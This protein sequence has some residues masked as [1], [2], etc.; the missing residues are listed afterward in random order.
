[1]KATYSVLVFYRTL[2]TEEKHPKHYNKVKGTAGIHGQLFEYKFCALVFLR[3]INHGLQFKL[4]SNVA[5][6]GVFDDVEIEYLDDISRISHFFV[7]L[8]SKTRQ[9]ITVKNLLAEKGDFSLRKYYESYIEIEEKFNCCEEGVKINGRI[10]ES[11]FIIYTNADVEKGLQSNE[12]IEVGQENFLM[13]GSSVLQFSEEKHK[14]IYEHLQG[15][16]KHR[17]FL[18]R[19]RIMYRQANEKEM[20][21]HITH[22]LQNNMKLSSCEL[23]LAYIYFRDFIKEWWQNC[24]Y[25]L[26]ETN[27]AENDPLQKT[28]ENVRTTLVAKVLEQRKSELGELCIKYKESAIRVMKELIEPNKALLIFAPG[29]STTLTAAKIHQMLSATTHIILNL[30]QLVRY[31]PEVMF[32][33]NNRFN[34]LVV[35]GQNS[36]E[37]FQVIFDE[38]ARILNECGVKKKFVFISSRKGN[39][40][41]IN[42]LRCTFCSKLREEYD[43]WKVTDIITESQKVLLK[44]KVYFQGSELQLNTIVKESDVCMLNALDS[45]SIS[46]LI[47]NEKPSIGVPIDDTLEYYIERTLE[48]SKQCKRGIPYDSDVLPAL[49]EDSLEEPQVTR[50]YRKENFKHKDSDHAAYRTSLATKS[51]KQPTALSNEANHMPSLST[52]DESLL[53]GQNTDDFGNEPLVFE[54]KASTVWRP[55]TLLEGD[56]R[57]ILVIAEP[58]MGK[59]TLLN[60]VAKQTRERH[61]DTWIVRVNINNY[62]SILHRMKTN[63]CD[64]NCA[65]KLL[66]EAAKVKERDGVQLEGELF[67]YSY[68]F[69]GNMVV[70]MDGVDEVSPHY[71]E[72]VIQIL[73]I[74][75]KTKVIKI[76]VTSRHPMKGQLEKEFQ[77]Q[78]YSLIPFSEEDQKRFLVKFWSKKCLDVKPDCLEN[79]ANRVV[80]LSIK[81]LSVGEKHFMGLPLQ[82]MLLAEMFEEN[83]K[84]CYLSGMVNLPEH[85]NLV[86]LYDLYIKKKWDIYLSEKKISDRTNVNVLNDDA[87]LYDSFIDNH[88]AAAL[89][90]IFSR[91]HLEKLTDKDIPK[92]ARDFL[93]K[94]SE[95]LEKTG[96]ISDVID[97]RPVFQHRTCAEYFVARWLCDHK[98]ASQ[99]FLRDHI[100]ELGFG[101]VRRMVD[102]IL[103]KENRVHL[104]VLNSDVRE[105]E[106]LLRRKDSICEKDH[107]GR[108]ALHIAVSSRSPEIIRLLLEHGADIMVPDTFLGLS[109]VQYASRMIDWEMLSLIMEKRPKVREQVLYV[110]KNELM[111]YNFS[112]LRAAAKYGHT[113]LLTY[114]ISKDN[115]VNVPLPGDN[116]T[117]LHEAAQSDQIETVKTLVR[118]GAKPDAADGIGKTP[119]HVSAESGSYNVVKFMVESQDTVQKTN[120]LGNKGIFERTIQ[121]LNRLNA[122]DKYGN[123]PLHLASAAGNTNIVRYL[124]SAGSDLKSRNVRREYPLTLAARCGN[125]DILEFLLKDDC[126]PKYEEAKVSA[127]TA[128]ISAGHVYTMKLLL[129]LGAPVNKGENEKPIHAA[130]RV[131]HQEIVSLL[132][133]H[134]ASLDSRTVNGNTALH[135]ASEAGHISLVKYLVERERNDVNSL[136]SENETPLHLA[137]R[138][139]RENL[140]K[141]LVENGCNINATTDYHATC[142]HVAC[143]NGLY[144]IV[145]YLLKHGANVNAKTSADKTPLHIAASRGQTKIVKLLLLNHANVSL[146]DKDGTTALLAASREGNQET[147]RFIVEHGGNIQDSDNNRNTIAHFAV[148]KE[149]YSTL[150]FLSELDAD[151]DVR[152]CNGHTPLLQAVRQ[153]NIRIVQYLLE[154]NADVNVQGNDGIRP[155]DFAVLKGKLELIR[156]LLE[157]KARSSKAGVHLVEA[158]RFGYLDLL[159]CFVAMGDE[160]NAKTNKG[161]TPLH[162]ACKSGQIN[163]VQ[164]LSEHGA[165]LDLQD[166]SG[167]TALHFAVSRGHINVT[168]ALVEK[169][170]NLEVVN[171]AGSTAL[172]IAAKNG[173]LNIARFL[174]ENG[175]KVD[176]RNDKNETALLVATAQGHENIVKVLMAHGAGIGVR[177]IVGTT[178]LDIA[179]E[180]GYF[181]IT[182]LIKDR[183]EGRMLICSERPSELNIAAE[184]GHLEEV[185]RLVKAGMP[186]DYGDRFGR[187]ALWGAASKGHNAIIRF[188]TESGSC[189]NIPDSEGVTPI[190]I[191]ARM[192]HWEAVDEFMEHDP[193]IRP[194]SAEYL[195]VHLHRASASDDMTDLRILLKCGI[196]VD[197]KNE[198]G[199]TPLHVAANHGYKE[200]TQLLLN[201]GANVSI[202]DRDGKTPLIS[203]AENGYVELVQDLVNADAILDVTCKDGLTP[204]I[205]AARYGHVEVCREL[206]RGGSNVNLQDNLSCTP[207][208]SAATNGHAKVI[209]VLLYHGA[210]VDIPDKSG[211]TPLSSAAENGHVEVIEDLLDH[212]ANVDTADK[213]GRTPLISAAANGHLEVIRNLLH[214][215]ASV[216]IADKNGRTPLSSGAENGNVEVTRELL[217][218]GASVNIVD[219]HGCTPLRFSARNGH[220]EVIR[221]LINHGASVD[222]RDNLGFTALSNAAWLGHLDVVRLLLENHAN[223]DNVSNT[224]ITAVHLA[225]VKGYFSVVELLVYNN[226]NTSIRSI[227]GRTA[228]DCAYDQR[229]YDI[230]KY[231]RRVTELL[232]EWKEATSQY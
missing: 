47:A 169:S 92:V 207:L 201:N 143:E 67:I 66:T 222:I 164:Y 229:H 122:R 168:Q 87:A 129:R 219:I 14:D 57:V 159:H 30:Q 203:A 151:L 130:S 131:G 189:T 11:L 209:R 127:L 37:N 63:V 154:K 99:T 93:K 198:D 39:I 153:G 3:A 197:I 230:G 150:K 18:R 110:L 58:G 85:I 31:M 56:D 77:C 116:G 193:T 70:L 78:S 106:K 215:G 95:G 148:T 46:L 181:A 72:E 34:V 74:L 211:R 9:H 183:A 19:F 5:E 167:N 114:M 132:L 60:H 124:I 102:S 192:C 170:A 17:E 112:V 33:W 178:A 186:L 82:S 25:F 202:V 7:Q 48:C 20:D 75:S 142:L 44:K 140:V 36:S 194:E 96:I 79:L 29:R 69:T 191:A 65:I 141:Y 64:E 88:K 205:Y 231:L 16:P 23:D 210:N 118:L 10:D 105:V 176:M 26:Q 2:D 126:D 213:R 121:K 226:A 104:A 182:Q 61:P 147:V 146:R 84:Q 21:Q 62:T 195:N 38:T 101:I 227:D 125:N 71:T 6:R 91:H 94:I 43:D 107:G 68:N 13:T 217:N 165:L 190:N 53:W 115:Y 136:N 86:L 223:V 54:R 12:V 119:L 59:S 158:A 171:A 187:T 113:D 123:T 180:K 81:H 133:Q 152:N 228:A 89:V 76:W 73:R 173:F 206:L 109:P 97:G 220:V 157:R 49:R 185:E 162:A 50:P 208:N 35:E 108:T 149:N 80:E 98:L 120:K 139:G 27:C 179:K 144:A 156:I 51:E 24:N 200:V 28:S 199:Y 40:Q 90:A 135:L 42:S 174:T 1:M 196:E 184:N 216:D 55:S 103:V 145:E 212:G 175:E 160:I 172:H 224:G 4:A 225:A 214:Y 52:K 15:L 163:T 83:V 204:L 221:V 177:D 8:K 134:G 117:L 166:N 32:A 155:L 161:E 138:N 218:H 111:D 41:Q 188:L 100:F 128:A 232:W 137:V 22:D 45:D